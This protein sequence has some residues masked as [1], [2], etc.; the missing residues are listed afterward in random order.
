MVVN[1]VATHPSLPPESMPTKSHEGKLVNKCA[2]SICRWLPV[3]LPNNPSKVLHMPSFVATRVLSRLPGGTG[4]I[5]PWPCTLETGRRTTRPRPPSPTK[6]PLLATRIHLNPQGS[7]RILIPSGLS[8]LGRCT[9]MQCH[10]GTQ[11]QFHILVCPA[12]NPMP[13]WANSNHTREQPGFDTS[14]KHAKRN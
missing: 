3:C 12:C 13:T 7:P 9:Q 14:S 4:V 11:M 2:T 10:I 1:H 8:M 5:T 6:N